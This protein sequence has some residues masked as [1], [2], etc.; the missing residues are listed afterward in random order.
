MT[1]EWNHGPRAFAAIVGQQN[2][3]KGQI[4]MTEREQLEGKARAAQ[5]RVSELKAARDMAQLE[6]SMTGAG[7]AVLAAL[8]ADLEAQ[9]EPLLTERARLIAGHM[10]RDAGADWQT[11]V[12][13]YCKAHALDDR[14][15]DCRMSAVKAM[16]KSGE[17]TDAD[18]LEDC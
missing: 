13:D 18:L 15:A 17:L 10:R 6:A 14:D 8:L 2:E 9:I 12:S 11:L 7:D 4:E 3:P 16:L 5:K 1:S